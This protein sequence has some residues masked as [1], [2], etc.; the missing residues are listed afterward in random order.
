MW[1]G[2]VLGP[3]FGEILTSLDPTSS[4]ICP[5]PHAWSLSLTFC[6]GHRRSGID[7]TAA[8]PGMRHAKPDMGPARQD[9]D[10][11][12]SAQSLCFTSCM[13]PRRPGGMCSAVPGI[14]FS[15]NGSVFPVLFGLSQ[16]WHVLGLRQA[17]HRISQSRISLQPAEIEHTGEPFLENTESESVASNLS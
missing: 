13:D 11:P 5:P 8:R 17:W 4:G 6:T 10:P 9:T 2:S 15:R 14:G 12:V 7:P 16:T 3:D 1:S